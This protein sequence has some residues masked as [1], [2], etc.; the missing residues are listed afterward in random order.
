MNKQNILIAAFLALILSLAASP[1][2]AGAYD[3]IGPCLSG[4][5][6]TITFV[7]VGDLHARF[8]LFEDKYSKIRAFLNTVRSANPY[9]VFTDAGDDHEK[10][11]VAEQYSRGDAVT[12]ATF[13]MQFDVRTIGNHDFAWGGEHLLAF[14]RDPHSMVLSSN[15]HY[16]AGGPDPLGLGSVDYGVL[17][18]GC[19]KIG[20]FGM[21][22]SPWDELDE[23]SYDDYLPFLHT[24]LFTSNYVNLAQAIVN[25]HR[26]EVDL[27]VMVSHLGNGLDKTIAESVPGI[28]LVLGGHSHQPPVENLITTATST[29]LVVLPDFYGDGITRVDMTVDLSTHGVSTLSY[30]EQ[31]VDGLSVVDSTVHDAISAIMTQYAPDA[32][33][34]IAYLK[35]TKDNDGNNA[36]NTAFATIAAK[37]AIQ[38]FS[39]DAALLDPARAN[40]W[41]AWYAGAITTQDLIDGYYI[42][43]QRPNTP[44]TNSLYMA[45]VSGEALQLMTAQTPSWVYSGPTPAA[46]STY[47]VIV[48]KAAALDPDILFPLAPGVTYSSVAYLSETWEMLAHYGINRTA[49]CLYLDVDSTL[50]PLSL[51]QPIDPVTGACGTASGS[52]FTALPTNNLCSSGTVSAIDGNG[53]WTWSC[54]GW[55]GG[56]TTNSCSANKMTDGSCGATNAGIITAA[57]TSDLCSAGTASI[58]SG[59]GPWA[60]NCTGL[61]GGKTDRCLAYI[62]TWTVTPLAGAHGGI[63]P[64]TPQI[65]THGTS[66]TFT[67]TPNTG[68]RASVGGTCGGTLVDTTYTTNAIT[69]ACTVSATFTMKQYTV[70]T[71]P[72]SNGTISPESR[73]VSYDSTTTFTVTP[74]PGYHLDLVSG[75][76]GTLSGNTYTTG[77]VTADCTVSAAF[78]NAAPPAPI[79]Y[80]PAAG[81]EV[82]SLT[83]TLSVNAVIDPDGDPVT[84]TYEV[85]LDSYLTITA[86]RATNQGASWTVSSA[87]ADNTT[88]YWR[89]QATDGYLNSN[90][91]STADFFVNTSNDPP[92]ITV[93]SP[94][95]TTDISSFTTYTITWTATDP[96]SNPIIT[97]Y[98]DTSG[99]GYNGT[100][101]VSGLHNGV[102]NGNYAWNV[103][104]LPEGTYFI[105]ARIDDGTTVVYSYASGALFKSTQDLSLN[106]DL[107][108]DNIIDSSDALRALRIVAGL[109]VPTSNDIAHGDVAPMV[110][111]VPRPDGTIDIGDVVVILRRAVGLISW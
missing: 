12:A 92:T 81:S 104:N 73:T 42:E 63:N 30:Q 16:D 23:Q 44:G 78:V 60:W 74:I 20:F 33:K 14:S 82:F 5:T 75:C 65:V 4:P 87:L 36:A 89:A 17:Q 26:A 55:H 28:D 49:Q 61:N 70:T 40:P 100:Q 91:M 84:Y 67:I 106:G 7:H 29:T 32:Q 9:T 15:T 66:T 93:D 76:S 111:G 52:S 64:S 8:D 109:I 25:A 59:S 58:V 103:T 27:M 97:L 2:D 19:V 50:S 102:P 101:I 69:A 56:T 45:E 85:Y 108:D 53:P 51:C 96:D 22:G 10:G 38:V 34:P 11:S 57:P 94:A 107:N 99:S 79:V 88:Y 3:D 62:Q 98:Y 48:H 35:D 39:A 1:D 46:G 95:S 72:G 71:S 68:Y 13:A 86:A 24:T 77:H 83:P 21:T 90:W 43:R 54:V 41:G 18:V 110:N 47:R 80:A 6:Q 31:P 37:A 105:Y